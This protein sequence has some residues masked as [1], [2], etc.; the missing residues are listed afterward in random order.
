MKTLRIIL[1]ILAISS[2][3]GWLSFRIYKA[4]QFESN[5]GTNLIQASVA[6]GAQTASEKLDIAIKYLES[7]NLTNGSTMIIGNNNYSTDIG[8]WYNNLK[9]LLMEIQSTPKNM[10]QL[11]QVNLRQRIRSVIYCPYSYGIGPRGISVYPHNMIVG[12]WGWLSLFGLVA[13]SISY[14]PE[15]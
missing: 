13:L 3:L 4:N 2:T 7:Q 15:D 12:I 10:S 8:F 9:N 5:V 11:E 1:L 6:I 14:L